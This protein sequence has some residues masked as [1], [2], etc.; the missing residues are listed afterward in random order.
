MTE[1]RLAYLREKANSLPL[2]PG[3]YLMKREDGGI[4]YV[5][6]SRRL[7]NR[8]SSYFS[9]QE[10]AVKTARM[11]AQVYDFDYILCETEI[12]ALT[13]ENLL[14]KKHTPKYNVKLK[15][16]KSYPYLKITS[17]AY[18]RLVITRD[19]KSDGGKYFG[20]YSGMSVAKS[21]AETVTRL[22]G[23][24][25]C[26]RRFPEDIGRDR[27]C[28]YRQMG[29]CIAPCTGEISQEDY[30]TAVKNAEQVLAGRTSSAAAHL[31]ERMMAEAEAE[32]FE[33]AAYYRD[34]LEALRRLTDKQKVVGEATLNADALALFESETVSVLSCLSV[35][36]GKLQ[37]KN[38]FL[39]NP[40][41]M[42]DGDTLLSFLHGH[43][44]ENAAIPREILLGFS[45]SEEDREIL[46]SA[47][48]AIAS[49]RVIVRTPERGKGR[50]L[51]EMAEKNARER[52]ARY[53]ADTLR[54][55]E[56][57]VRLAS[58]L[59][60]ETLP[61][62]IEAYDISNFGNEQ[63]T[64]SM[65]VCLKG[66]LTP[67][68]YRFFR[69]KREHADDYSSMREALCRRITHFGDGTPS[70]SEIPDLI[71]LDG[72]VGHVR[73]IR[74]LFEE[75]G[76][77][78]PVFGMIKDDFHK[79][80]VLT[81]GTNEIQIIKEQAVFTLIYKIQEEAH[82][83]AVS[84]MSA[85]KRKTLKKS[86][87]E[88]LHGIGKVKAAKLYAAYGSIKRMKEAPLDSFYEIRGITR[89][90]AETVYR[91]LHP[92]SVQNGTN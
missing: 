90:D 5:G 68:H 16:A 51:C 35:R 12:E 36:E 83:F 4:L 63:I 76:I 58:L 22:F 50:A 1:Q 78:I 43:Y 31:E 77:D 25:T 79:T 23:L 66:K 24:P 34:S 9:R 18:P 38:D 10:M 92:E 65:A 49:H 45:C 26:R 85:A 86:P 82:R 11:V 15:D 3:V 20:P 64:A 56:T 59:G 73:T 17:G 46:S 69:I 8:V 67:S 6:K 60:L 27:P 54:D 72:G 61:D 42:S 81:D 13:L 88:D 30:R 52:A 55:D 41:E 47:L 53:A 84:R 91:F 44:S 14:I 19:R 70:F 33:F 21:V 80:R 40:T 87:L 74:A 2:C 7:K 57:L 28:L 37:S 29:R 71:L 75:Q 89:A 32:H 62:R 39:F 48:S